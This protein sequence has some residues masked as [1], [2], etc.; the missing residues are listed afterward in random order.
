MADLDRLNIV[1]AA[2]MASLAASA[3]STTAR[4]RAHGRALAYAAPAVSAERLDL[5]AGIVL[6]A[7][8]R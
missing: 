7:V 3:S 4:C 2:L 5:V 8:A 6:K 1:R